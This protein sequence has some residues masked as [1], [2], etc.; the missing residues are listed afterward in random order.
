ME[1][2][3]T[4][5]MSADPPEQLFVCRADDDDGTEPPETILSMN[6]LEAAR[7]QYRPVHDAM[8]QLQRWRDCLKQPAVPTNNTKQGEEE[9][10]PA[11]TYADLRQFARALKGQERAVIEALC[12]AG[13]ELPLG[14]LAVK[15][16]V[17]WEDPKG[18]FKN[19]QD[20]LNDKLPAQGWRL[21]RHNNTAKL[22]SVEA[23]KRRGK[24][25]SERLD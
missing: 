14:D 6:Q 9:N 12:D 5:L 2:L 20:R 11:D 4:A 23:R 19:A 22:I 24:A 25:P 10:P 21:I 3:V 15:D 17:D 8:A 18:Q 1:S 7:A 13:G 16:G